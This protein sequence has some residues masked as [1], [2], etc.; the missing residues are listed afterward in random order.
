MKKTFTLLFTVGMMALVQAQPGNRDNRDVRQ[1][2]QRDYN[3]QREYNNPRDR[4][5]GYDNDRRN[6][7]YETAFN[8][9]F[10]Y[11]DRFSI[12]RNISLQIERINRVYDYR[13]QQV[14]R[15]FFLN[16]WEKKRQIR[17][18]EEQR[19]WELQRVYSRCNDYG[20]RYREHNHHDHYYGRN[21]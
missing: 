10:R 17:F 21:F 5:D 3:E 15:D 7:G 20:K 1:P 16:W 9:D 4:N 14:R 2:D 8:R 19:Q 6:A 12:E 11:D 18:L 13:I